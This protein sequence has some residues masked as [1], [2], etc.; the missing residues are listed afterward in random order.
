MIIHQDEEPP[1]EV[2][3]VRRKATKTRRR[4]RL[5][6]SKLKLFSLPLSLSS[7]LHLPSLLFYLL[8]FLFC[9][10][11][12]TPP[13]LHV[14][15]EIDFTSSTICDTPNCEV[16]DPSGTGRCLLCAVLYVLDAVTFDCRPD[17]T[18]RPGQ[19]VVSTSLRTCGL[20][21]GSDATDPELY[22]CK[23]C[24]SGAEGKCLEAAEGY[25]K[26]A[27]TNAGTACVADTTSEQKVQTCQLTVSRLKFVCQVCTNPSD[28]TTNV[29]KCA[30]PGP[31]YCLAADTNAATT[32]ITPDGTG[33]KA[34]TCEGTTGPGQYKCKTCLNPSDNASPTPS[35]AGKCATPAA[36]YCLAADTNEGTVCAQTSVGGSAVQACEGTTVSLVNHL[37]QHSSPGSQ[38]QC[39][40]CARPSNNNNAALTNANRCTTCAD[41][42]YLNNGIYGGA[43]VEGKCLPIPV[44][45]CAKGGGGG[46]A[47]TPIGDVSNCAGCLH[48]MQLSTNGTC[49]CGGY[50]ALATDGSGKC[51]ACAAN[52]NQCISATNCTVSKAGMLVRV[53]SSLWAPVK[54]ERF[55]DTCSLAT[56]GSCTKA[57]YAYFILENL[58]T[59]T[60]SNCRFGPNKTHCSIP[61]SGYYLPSVA[62]TGAT[63][64]VL[65]CAAGCDECINNTYCLR[66]KYPGYSLRRKGPL[67]CPKNCNICTGAGT[68]TKCAPGHALLYGSCLSHVS[69]SVP[70][71]SGFYL[72]PATK[73]QCL[74]CFGTSTTDQSIYT[75]KTCASGLEGQCLVAAE[76]HCKAANRLEGTTCIADTTTPSKVQTCQL[77]TSRLAYACTTCLKPSDG[78]TNTDQCS[79]P[80]PGYCLA[81]DTNAGTDCLTPNGSA[82][83]V[84][85][86][87]GTSA[88]G[89]YKCTSC[90]RPSDNGQT[91]TNANL[92]I[93]PGRG[94][95]LADDTNV[96][97]SC[98]TSP[99]ANGAAIQACEGTVSPTDLK[100]WSCSSPSDNAAS[101]PTNI[102]DCTQS[103]PG[104]YIHTAGALK[105]CPAGCHTCTA[106]SCIVCAGS[107][108][109]Y[110][111]TAG[112]CGCPDG[113]IPDTAAGHCTNKCASLCDKCSSTAATDCEVP[114]LG[115]YLAVSS[116][117]HSLAAAN[118][119]GVAT[120][121][122]FGALC[123]ECVPDIQYTDS[124]R[125][126]CTVPAV[127]AFLPHP[128]GIA[129]G[130]RSLVTPL[131]CQ[132]N[133]DA[134][135]D[136]Y[137][138]LKCTRPYVL[139]G[140][141][142][143]LDCPTSFVVDTHNS[144]QCK[145]CPANCIRCASDG[146]CLRC[147]GEYFLE[148]IGGIGT[149]KACTAHC[150]RCNHNDA[151]GSCLEPKSGY[152]IATS[153]SASSAVG[154][155]LSVPLTPG[156]PIAC[157]GN[158]T[159]CAI[160]YSPSAVASGSDQCQYPQ[161]GHFLSSTQALPGTTIAPNGIVTGYALPCT[162]NCSSC[163]GS[164]ETACTVANDGYGIDATTRK[165]LPCLANC[166]K[167]SIPTSC[168]V[169]S[170]GYYVDS[171]GQPQPCSSHCSK[172]QSNTQCTECL[173]NGFVLGGESGK[174][175]CKCPLGSREGT[176]TS[177]IVITV[178]A[179]N[180]TSSSSN[181]STTSTTP[182]PPVLVET[183][184]CL[185][186][187]SNC[188]V[189]TG[190]NQC[191]R[192]S[193]NFYLLRNSSCV[194]G[195]PAGT[196]A[197][198]ETMT[199]ESCSTNC[200]QCH[201]NTFCTQCS[202]NYDAIVE[203]TTV[204]VTPY[205]PVTLNSTN[206][207]SDVQNN[208]LNVTTTEFSLF[209]T[210]YDSLSV[211]T[212]NLTNITFELANSNTSTGIL[213]SSTTTHTCSATK[214]E[215]TN[216]A[217]C[218]KKVTG[219]VCSFYNGAKRCVNALAEGAT[220][221]TPP[222][223]ASNPIPCGAGLVC[224]ARGNDTLCTKTGQ[225]QILNSN[226]PEG[227]VIPA[228]T[229]IGANVV[230]EDNSILVDGAC[231][232]G[233]NST[234]G[235]RVNIKTGAEIGP[236]STVGSNTVVGYNVRTGK[237]DTIETNVEIGAYG[238]I[239]ENAVL[240]QNVLIG[241][242]VSVGSKSVVGTDSALGKQTIIGD[243][244]VLGSGELIAAASRESIANANKELN[245]AIAS[246]TITVH[247]NSTTAARSIDSLARNTIN[248]T[249]ASTG[250]NVTITAI[251]VSSFGAS[252]TSGGLNRWVSTF[253]IGNNVTVGSRNYF[254][255]HV[256]V[257]D[258]VVIGSDNYF[259]KGARVQAGAQLNVNGNR[260]LAGALVTNSSEGVPY[261]GDACPRARVS[262]GTM[263]ISVFISIFMSINSLL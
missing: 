73:Q 78:T 157:A 39:A 193:P 174:L 242:H 99:Q 194:S 172:C 131:Q 220:C 139:E 258:N 178:A 62:L 11:L 176:F 25:C 109:L 88:P 215:C 30:T 36:G 86:C 46:T 209:Y 181:S 56:A 5:F 114:S 79:V 116:S 89:V 64:S 238:D 182:A 250:Q 261:S 20:C 243:S 133:C 4:R 33:R 55:C 66:A 9:L 216:D 230:F 159:S 232:V 140:N 110:G 168:T 14:A 235:G 191:S 160:C 22:T 245:T 128:F 2:D 43:G 106:D 244:S 121:C 221:G 80:G 135:R 75:C 40:V 92:C 153:A 240:K 67:Q 37:T 105:T 224:F 241:D 208:D 102:G 257:G 141:N 204:V 148:I 130:D 165:V 42:F 179:T 147:H 51:L 246:S 87:E 260:Y 137:T 111:D 72:D 167:C 183:P 27:N 212:G 164:A 23:T 155:A 32:C 1:G 142:C 58:P 219:S 207:T 85:T 81:A 47:V 203:T 187:V 136:Q 60:V 101:N 18:C 74:P 98:K 34:V 123:E 26:A 15:G 225:S 154:V 119:K 188:D 259:E 104:Y 91:P 247:T 180:I 17:N 162:G 68:C 124:V 122:G 255:S 107:L 84:V 21:F 54:C 263:A 170:S 129:A 103:A 226:N 63:S 200:L 38:Y 49:T 233:H 35:N 82:R 156:Y 120:T 158:A 96:G 108:V 65:S 222:N 94:Y 184:A 100:C 90:K 185:S 53:K 48:N 253:K 237:N 197:V 29:D 10:T 126:N 228:G 112:T 248:V 190:S 239:G 211:S 93:E 256:V 145:A 144:G 3:R 152:Y 150:L 76:G 166:Q 202:L 161:P 45:G 19:Y 210:N 24:S 177:I 59:K 83:K 201:N 189:C 223:S 50:R 192:C 195:C 262:M 173:P 213:N 77:T 149:C 236:N 229:M 218:S 13:V 217:E 249:S 117:D 115:S 95:C 186:C 254:D 57:S 70:C 44:Y 214:R 146:R 28:G 163:S 175:Q 52:C 206:T 227:L 125:T 132:P 41:G 205:V 231:V 118:A 97:T 16:C 31:G 198:N 134:C 196:F 127:G 143:I 6:Y 61:E 199:C 171:G 113:S 251:T 69:A 8:L 151:G 71:D 138:C 12:T 252:F 234:I 169:A 7:C